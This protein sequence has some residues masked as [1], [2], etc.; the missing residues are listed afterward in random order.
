MRVL[1]PLLLLSTLCFGQYKNDNV[2]YKTVYV[3]DF[4]KQ[5]KST[6]NALLLD[7]RSQGE[8]DD[9]ST[10]SGLNIGRLNA[11]KHISIQELPARWKELAEYKDKPI[12]VYCSHSQ[13][14]RRASKMLADSGF[15]NVIN[16][17]GGLTYL[18]MINIQQVCTDMYSTGNT[19]KLISPFDLCN[20]LTASK[21]VVILDVRKDSAFNHIS[22]DERL[23]A[24]GRL[25]NTL[26]ISLADLQKSTEKVPKNKKILVIDDFGTDAA[27]AAKLLSSGGWKDVNV[28]FNGLETMI[29]ADKKSLGCVNQYWSNNLPYK[30]VTAI[31]FDELAKKEKVQLL[32]VRVAEEFNNQSK[33]QW[34]NIGNIKSAINIPEPE[35]KNNLSLIAKDAPVVI[36]HFGNSPE[37]Y[38]AAK[39]LADAGYKKVYVLSGGLFNLRWQ[40][41]NLKG[42]AVLKD[43][44]VNVPAENL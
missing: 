10:S 28:L 38:R 21:D 41:A 11:N 23:N 29:T 6:P 44:V 32:D 1:F 26:H 4:C 14:S 31:E 27:I 30:T 3:E 17:N 12:Y 13:R 39:L 43:W 22:T 16:I 9:T 34:R 25:K 40:A 24:Q 19:Y 5:F 36:Y 37:S 33:T 15:T 35:L 20:F 8:Y 18:N 7:V 2:L 42:K